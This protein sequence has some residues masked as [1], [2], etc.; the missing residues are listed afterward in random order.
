M[1]RE[2]TIETT[3]LIDPLMT[4]LTALLRLVV[5][6]IAPL[7]ELLIWLSD[8]LVPAPPP[9]AV[10]SESTLELTPLIE[11]LTTV[12]TAVLRLVTCEVTVL[13][14]PLTMTLRLATS[15]VAV[16][17]ATEVLVVTPDAVASPTLRKE[18]RLRS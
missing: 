15:E 2:L 4:V 11:P 10:L 14:D 12:L 16:E 17:I 18:V 1:L 5:E 13:T 7:K 8:V 9:T 6:D 3:V